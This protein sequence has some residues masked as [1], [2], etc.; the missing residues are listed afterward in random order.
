MTTKECNKHEKPSRPA[1]VT[2]ASKDTI[3]KKSPE[4]T[5]KVWYPTKDLLLTPVFK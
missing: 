1:K 3:H 4:Q 5:N 2:K